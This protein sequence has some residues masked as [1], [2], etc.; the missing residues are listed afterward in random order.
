MAKQLEVTIEIIF[1]AT[2]DNKKIFEPIFDLFQISEDEFSK[3]KILGYYGNPIILTKSVLTKNRAE[4]FVRNLI[5]K[6]PKAQLD[7]LL[8]NINMYFD[9]SSLFLR[10]GKNDLVHNIINLQQNNA[11]KIRI[12]IPIY[13]KSELEKTYKELLRI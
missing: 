8:E 11:M 10:I 4:D 1:H 3:E 13:K 2:E 12:K 7:E 5:S 9:D 6:I